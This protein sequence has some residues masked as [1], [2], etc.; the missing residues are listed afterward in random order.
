VGILLGVA[1]LLAPVWFLIR[2]G[3]SPPRESD[4]AVASPEPGPA[5]VDE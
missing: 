1:V 5:G 3:R 4:P 2:D